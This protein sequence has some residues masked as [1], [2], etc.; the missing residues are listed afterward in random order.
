MIIVSYFC[1]GGGDVDYDKTP[2]RDAHEVA[3]V[4]KLYFR[5]LSEPLVPSPMTKD[6]VAA[7]ANG[8]PMLH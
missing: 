1:T 8:I 3:G 7:G 6:F 4:V 5:E 2:I